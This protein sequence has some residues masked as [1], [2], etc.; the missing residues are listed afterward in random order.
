MARQ[1]QHKQLLCVGRL[2]PGVTPRQAEASLN[3]LA[4]QLAKQYPN[5]NEGQ[6]IKV[7]PTGFIIPELRGAVVSFT[8]ILMAAVEARSVSHLREPRRIVIGAFN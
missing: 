3:M 8:W 6:S 2:K 7:V 5:D 1:S 4:V